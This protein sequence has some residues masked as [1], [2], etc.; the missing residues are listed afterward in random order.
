[1]ASEHAIGFGFDG[2]NSATCVVE[3]TLCNMKYNY[4]DIHQLRSITLLNFNSQ[5]LP[6]HIAMCSL[7]WNI[8]GM[9]F[10]CVTY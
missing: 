4:V 8:M 10:N 9:F 3:L 7:L 1:M 2:K 6:S 5:I